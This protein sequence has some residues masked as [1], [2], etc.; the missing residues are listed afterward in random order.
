MITY[1]TTHKLSLGVAAIA[2]VSLV[3]SWFVRD[4]DQL[5]IPFVL[6][7]VAGMVFMFVHAVFFPAY[8]GR[9]IR[10]TETDAGFNLE[11]LNKDNE[12]QRVDKINLEDLQAFP[13]SITPARF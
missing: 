2:V 11:H 8:F 4:I 3:A 13:V 12:V 9:F 5:R 1:S 6:V 10:V 7:T